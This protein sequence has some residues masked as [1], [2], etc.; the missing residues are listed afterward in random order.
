ILHDAG[1][2]VI[3]L[4]FACPVRKISNM[5]RGGIMLQ[6]LPRAVSI[7]AAVRDALPPSAVT[8][9]SLRRGFDDTQESAERFEQ[10][11]EA[12]WAYGYQAVR[13]HGRTVVQ[14]YVGPSRWDVL[15]H[16]KSRWPQRTILG[17]GDV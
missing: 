12:A 4:N 2:D 9:V 6:D 17:S 13:V 3:D 16:V 7:L 5:A 10:I 1:Y 8:T 15:K 11:I 14:K